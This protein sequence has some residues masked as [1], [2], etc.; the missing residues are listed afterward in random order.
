VTESPEGERLQKALAHA[1]VGSRRAVEELIRAKRVR[2]DGRV[3]ILG[4][5]VDPAKSKVEVDGSIVPL[6]PDLV[7]Y[8]L[9]KPVGVVTSADDDKG[10]T[11]VLDIVDLDARVWPAG[12][13]DMDSEGALVLTNDGELTLRLTHPRF[14]VHKTYLAEVRGSPSR[15]ALKRLERGVTL[16]DGP[17][18][19]L[20]AR[21]VARRDRTSLVE[22][23]MAEGRKREV[24]RMLDA[25]G[26]EAVALART[27]IGPVSL[28]RLKPGT[29]RKLSPE[30]VRAL[31]RAAEEDEETNRHVDK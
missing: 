12:R 31:Y 2:V 11:S 13:L 22:V 19:A 5:R 16:D 3:A 7:Y 14:G 28:G 25:I 4:Q 29:F 15:P 27:A 21:L 23:V 6:A 8:L 18:R 30:E 9:N 17:A 20:A 1:G 24:R 10:R 26:H